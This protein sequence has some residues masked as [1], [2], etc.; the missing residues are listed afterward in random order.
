M[1]DDSRSQKDKYGD[2]STNYA[3][4]QNIRHRSNGNAILCNMFGLS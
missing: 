1:G 3:V 2:L 4:M